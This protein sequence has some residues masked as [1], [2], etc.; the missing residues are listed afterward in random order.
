MMIS[1]A[2]VKPKLE[3]TVFRT[4]DANGAIKI[5]N[6]ITTTTIKGIL[7]IKNCHLGFIKRSYPLWLKFK[8]QEI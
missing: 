6:I 2:C 3:Q 7:N 1:S 8:V 5:L 4:R